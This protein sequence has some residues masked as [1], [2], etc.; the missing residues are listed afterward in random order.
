MTTTEK[1][2]RLKKLR[3]QTPFVPFLLRNGKGE[4]AD[5]IDRFAFAFNESYGCAYASDG[6][7]VQFRLDSTEI[8][9]LEEAGRQ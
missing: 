3:L 9:E 4:E 8:Q 7:W 5:V 6:R 2:E 1:F